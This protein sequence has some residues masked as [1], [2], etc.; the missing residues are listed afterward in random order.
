M[1]A[2]DDA[3]A[4]YAATS[5]LDAARAKYS[6]EPKTSQGAVALLHGA[7]GASFG[8]ADELTGVAAAILDNPLVRKLR[9]KLGIFAPPEAPPVATTREGKPLA[10]PV[11]IAPKSVMEAYRGGRDSVRED[12]EQTRKDWPKTALGSEVATSILNPVKVPIKGGG[13][14]RS[15]VRAGADA[16]AYGAG[17]SDADLTNGEV[18]KFGGDVAKA[19]AVGLGAGAAGAGAAKVGTYLL[20]GK[21]D[22]LKQRVLN[23]FA[24]GETKTTPTQRKHLDKA[25]NAILEE[26][27]QGPDAKAVRSA[28]AGPAAKGREKLAP[29]VDRVGSKIDDGYEA[30]DKAGRATVD[31]AEYADRLAK[32]LNATKSLAEKRGI[33]KLITDFGE[34]VERNQGAPLSLREVRAF[35]TEIQGYAAS[36]IGGLNDHAAAKLKRRL[37]AVATDA[38]DDMLDRAAAGDKK[39]T[40]AAEQIRE[41]NRRMHALLTVDK[42]LKLREAAE[43]SQ[44]SAFARAADKGRDAVVGAGTAGLVSLAV[45]PENAIRNAGLGLG[46]GAVARS[47]PAVARAI[48]RGVTTR[49][50]E[51]T[52]RG[53]ADVRSRLAEKLGRP[54]A[55]YLTRRGSRKSDEE[56]ERR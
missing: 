38:M 24:E 9:E 20:G 15:A 51:A 50:I 28:A 41:N 44:R 46:I 16:A 22:R 37:S 52:Q 40:A 4:K 35:T 43:G 55:S 53:T 33:E 49:A 10:P 7:Q 42:V 29:I 13:I 8:T 47:L 54:V 17:A 3:R 48:D 23:E 18:L 14:V 12:L 19:G 21:V 34:L 1:S 30:F 27:V 56:E 6:D 11:D 39:L 32:A 2:L 45:D 26:V 31:S 36:A 5:A 25:G